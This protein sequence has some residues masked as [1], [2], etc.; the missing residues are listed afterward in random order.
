MHSCLKILLITALS[1][2]WA[3]PLA[4][5]TQSLQDRFSP[6]EDT[7][8][9]DGLCDSAWLYFQE[10]KVDSVVRYAE[11]A[12]RIAKDT[13]PFR[14]ARASL[15]LAY[16]RHDR[17]RHE[18]AIALYRHHIALSRQIGR[19]Y[20]TVIVE[21]NIARCFTHSGPTGQRPGLF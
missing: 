1:L 3:A 8:F 19:D 7:T 5:Q 16:G 20:D 17:F 14:E 18:E 9:V 11:E 21:L 10:G 6:V 12:Y 4:S 2:H 15:L 13:M